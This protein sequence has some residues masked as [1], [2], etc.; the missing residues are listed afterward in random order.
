MYRPEARVSPANADLWLLSMMLLF[1]T[2]SPLADD[3]RSARS[4]FSD[5][6]AIAHRPC[7]KRSLLYEEELDWDVAIQSAP[8]RPRKTINVKIKYIGRSKPMP[9][10]TS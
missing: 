7:V 10:E 2:Q 5:W 8:R 4:V 6:W 3:D 9:E 1:S